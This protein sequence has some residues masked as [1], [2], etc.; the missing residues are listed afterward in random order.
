MKDDVEL[1]VVVNNF[2]LKLTYNFNS[3]NIETFIPVNWIK[4]AWSSYEQRSFCMKYKA[5]YNI[6]KLKFLGKVDLLIIFTYSMWTYKTFFWTKN[7]L[8]QLL[9]IDADLLKMIS[10]V[11]QNSANLVVSLLFHWLTIAQNFQTIVFHNL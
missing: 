8:K 4:Y 11:L 7:V 6:V 10:P 1:L 5:T 2:S 3:L 9:A